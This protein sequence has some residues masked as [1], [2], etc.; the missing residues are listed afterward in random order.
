MDM[1]DEKRAPDALHVAL[2]QGVADGV[3]RI[4]IEFALA[5]LVDTTEQVVVQA[6][7]GTHFRSEASG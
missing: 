4:E 3:D 6:A 1:L 2:D 5:V 7:N